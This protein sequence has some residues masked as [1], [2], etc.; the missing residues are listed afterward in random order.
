MTD[1]DSPLADTEVHYLQSERL[2]VRSSSSSSATV[3]TAGRR[4]ARP[5]PS[6]CPTPTACSGPGRRRHPADAAVIA[7][8]A[9]AVVGIGYR[10][11]VLA[12]TIP[13]RSRDL[14][15]SD[16]RAYAELFPDQSTLG[17]GD[18]FRAFIR[19]ELI[20][21]VASCYGPHPDDRAY[22]GHSLG[23][24]FGVHTLLR[25][26]DTFHRTP[27][28]SPSLW[29]QRKMTLDVEEA[30]AAAHDDL[31][32]RVYVAIGGDET[33]DGRRREARE[34][35]GSDIIAEWEIDMVADMLE[36]VG[37]LE[38][39]RYPGF[40]LTA[41]VF[42]GEFHITVPALTLSRGLRHLFD[43]PR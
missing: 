13:L 12:E 41:E 16:D 29:W 42:D 1:D 35:S 32:A 21:W 20:P 23:G 25:A 8:T 43:A 36:L 5:P 14:T 34:L 31:P 33:L 18:A 3:A 22:Y 9:V 30:Y 15:P 38:K 27:T 39:R 24:L 19:D 17:G 6:T 37:R 4:R 10:T 40:E 28:S 2:P 7:P 26:P 11:G